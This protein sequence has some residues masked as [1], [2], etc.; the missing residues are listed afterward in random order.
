VSKKVSEKV[1]AKQQ[2]CMLGVA[3]VAS[4]RSALSEILLII[5]HSRNA[6]KLYNSEITGPAMQV[7]KFHHQRNEI[8]CILQFLH[9]LKALVSP[10][11]SIAN[12]LSRDPALT[13]L[14]LPFS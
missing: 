12:T 2:D 8:A 13:N 3:K 6:L 5:K 11:F 1:L 10:R 4:V 9:V 7:V 14:S